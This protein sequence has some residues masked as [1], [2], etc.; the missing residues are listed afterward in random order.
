MYECDEHGCNR[1]V[2]TLC[3]AVPAETQSLLVSPAVRFMCVACHWQENHTQ[4]KEQ[5]K[6]YHVSTLFGFLFLYSTLST[7]YVRDL[8]SMASPSSSRFSRG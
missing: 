1:V 7:F 8:P 2:C 5:R 3:L 6:P 4:A